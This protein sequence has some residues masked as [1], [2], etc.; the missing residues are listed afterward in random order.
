V[1]DGQ[2]ASGGHPCAQ[3]PHP[4]LPVPDL[5]PLTGLVL[6]CRGPPGSEP[7]L[8]DLREVRDVGSIHSRTRSA[9][10]AA[11]AIFWNSFDKPDQ[12]AQ[13]RDVA[14]TRLLDALDTARWM[15]LRSIATFDTRIA[16]LTFKHRY[17]YWRPYTALR[18]AATPEPLC[19]TQ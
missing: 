13:L 19:D 2:R 9:D 1:R 12:V 7:A 18:H 16:I 5:P 17:N 14:R 8:R 11:A 10:Q 6:C 15:A 4:H 3:T